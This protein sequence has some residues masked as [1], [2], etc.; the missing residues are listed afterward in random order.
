[1]ADLGITYD[2]IREMVALEDSHLP[3]N[4][5]FLGRLFHLPRGEWCQQ[6]P[7]PALCVELTCSLVSLQTRLPSVDW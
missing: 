4:I 1:M 3:A 5:V 2:V 7:V 6:G